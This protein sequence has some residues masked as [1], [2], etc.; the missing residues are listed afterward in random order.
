MCANQ[1]NVDSVNKE[2]EIIKAFLPL[3]RLLKN[4]Q[5]VRVN[6]ITITWTALHKFVCLGNAAD[7]IS[8]A[9][10]KSLAF[11]IAEYSTEGER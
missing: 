2:D 7:L 4:Q 3:H 6:P 5:R 11:L 8:G 1:A 9:L 10:S